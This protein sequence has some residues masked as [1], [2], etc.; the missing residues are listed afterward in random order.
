MPTDEIQKRLTTLKDL[1]NSRWGWLILAGSGFVGLGKLPEDERNRA[2]ETI[3]IV[4]DR[5][6]NAVGVSV[7]IITGLFFLIMFILKHFFRP[8]MEKEKSYAATVRGFEANF[9]KFTENCSVLIKSTAGQ[10]DRLS[11]I[12]SMLK[13]HH[14]QASEIKEAINNRFLPTFEDMIERFK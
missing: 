7:V 5:L 11:N 10:G 14:R 9:E 8:Y 2:L 3:G 13:D 4:V 1:A 12:E 6:D